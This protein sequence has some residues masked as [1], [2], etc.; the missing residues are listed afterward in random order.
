MK[1][2]SLLLLTLSSVLLANNL[3]TQEQI[4][5]AKA[6][7]AELQANVTKLESSLPKNIEKEKMAQ[8]AEQE[9]KNAFVT[10]TEL[11]FIS[12]SGNTDTTNYNLDLSVKKNWDKHVFALTFDGQ[13]AD[14][15]GI[16]TK[17]KF[18]SELSYD[19]E[20][21]ERFAFNYLVGYKD[22]KFSGY[23]YQSYTG[24]GIKY[25]A[26][27]EENHN[28]SLEGNILYSQDELELTSKTSNYGSFRAKGVYEWQILENLKF[29][30]DLSYR[31]ELED[32]NNYFVYSKTAFISKISDIFSFG[33]N[34]KIDYVNAPPA[35]TQ[36]SDKTLTA[37][38]I[39]DY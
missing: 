35:S 2:Y 14:D 29:A 27:K 23:N 28:L 22:D 10:H 8:L 39:A 18:F 3:S 6:K 7:I 12:T 1:K 25:K 9:K 17:N 34:Y 15:N 19:Y 37:N 20:F 32:S 24:P 31:T 36:H 4:A 11:G 26:I 13:Y 38:L 16:E 33:I 30:Q 21:T 5:Q